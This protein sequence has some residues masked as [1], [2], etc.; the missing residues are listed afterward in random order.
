MFIKRRILLV[1][2]IIGLS[3]PLIGC[4]TIAEANIP[5][6]VPQIS[7]TASYTATISATPFLAM[8][9]TPIVIP[10]S[11]TPTST[12]TPS[13][14][15]TPIPTDTP[16]PT[17]TPIPTETPALERNPAGH[18]IAP[19]LLYHHISD[20]GNG[21][22]YYV[23]LDDFR[24]QMEA[25]RDWGYTSIT[26]SD[27]VEVLINGGELPNRPVVI[28]FDDGNVNIYKNAFPI[29]HDLGFIGTFYIVANRL[30]SNGYVNAEQLREMA[31]AGWE[32]GSH[33][34]SHADL[35]LDYSTARY[36]ILQSQL[37]LEDATGALVNT[38]AYPYGKTDEFITDRVSEYGYRAGMGLGSSWEHTLGTLF[39]LSRIEI[40]GSYSLSK[41]A[42]LLPWSGN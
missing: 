32:I 22:R 25:L 42:S 9:N 36:E 33:S 17:D 19:I 2:L 20:A 24:A 21:N 23:T 40:Q 6:V 31:N 37:T 1:M 26:V 39:Y 18:V 12:F 11:Y 16:T 35:T 14:T 7:P 4:S 8:T 41:F 30:Q 29:M 38:F 27:L 5:T 34:M 15:S 10:P 13:P 3:V 28:T